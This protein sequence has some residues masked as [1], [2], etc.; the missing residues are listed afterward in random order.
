MG[1]LKTAGRLSLPFLWDG[2]TVLLTIWGTDVQVVGSHRG[3][4]IFPC[5]SLG[6]GFW[7]MSLTSLSDPCVC[8][9]EERENNQSHDLELDIQGRVLPLEN[10]NSSKVKISADTS[11]FSSQPEA[12]VASFFFHCLP[13]V[14]SKPE[15]CVL[16]SLGE[17]DHSPSFHSQKQLHAWSVG[18]FHLDPELC[19]AYALFTHPP[20]RH[21]QHFCSKI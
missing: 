13:S 12:R 3:G 11:S 20:N 14:A 10:C 1:I 9:S 6:G 5:S 2:R 16:Q 15:L 7:R 19:S 8:P 18:L 4:S 21:P 17:G